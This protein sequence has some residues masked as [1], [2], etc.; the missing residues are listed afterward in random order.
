MTYK[1]EA[2]QEAL[3]EAAVAYAEATR[4]DEG[5]VVLKLTDRDA[6]LV[7]LLVKGFLGE[8]LYEPQNTPEV[9]ATFYDIAAQLDEATRRYEQ[10]LRG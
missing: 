2:E 8:T 7:N 5:G 10:A 9:Q 6:F 1:G 3:L 4:E